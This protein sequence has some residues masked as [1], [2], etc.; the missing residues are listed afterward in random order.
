MYRLKYAYFIIVKVFL[1]DLDFAVMKVTFIH[2][3]RNSFN[4]G[5][6]TCKDRPPSQ[7]SV[8]AEQLQRPEM[9]YEV[10]LFRNISSDEYSK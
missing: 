9:E 2:A 5:R 4:K 10:R 6:F 3:N 7:C 1:P 8:C